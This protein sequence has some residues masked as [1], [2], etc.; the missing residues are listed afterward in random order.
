[1]NIAHEEGVFFSKILESYDYQNLTRFN[2]VL[3]RNIMR[4]QRVSGKNR[5]WKQKRF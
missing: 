3:V 5:F 4:L 1:M 2:E